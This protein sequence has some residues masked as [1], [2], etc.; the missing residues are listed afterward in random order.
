[1]VLLQLAVRSIYIFLVLGD[2]F[3]GLID[4]INNKCCNFRDGAQYYCLL[5][6]HLQV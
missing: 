1:M 2:S 4:I 5:C 3:V 6:I